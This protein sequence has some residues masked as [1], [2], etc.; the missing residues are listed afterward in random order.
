MLI[1]ITTV[2]CLQFNNHET[3][4]DLQIESFLTE[5]QYHLDANCRYQIRNTL[6]FQRT[7][8]SPCWQYRFEAL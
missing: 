8:Y 7:S 5:I 4:F 3:F 1:I 2:F 6:R